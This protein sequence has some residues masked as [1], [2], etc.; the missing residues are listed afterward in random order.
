[1][2][3]FEIQESVRANIVAHQADVHLQFLRE[4]LF[5]NLHSPSLTSLKEKLVH[6]KLAVQHLIA[7]PILQNILLNSPVCRK[8]I[9]R[10]SLNAVLTLL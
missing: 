1:M 6:N 10:N 2:F 4:Q 8:F 9:I 5:I 3:A 7:T